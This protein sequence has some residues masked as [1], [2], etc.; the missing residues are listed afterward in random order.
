M[1][2]TITIFIISLLSP[3]KTYIAKACKKLYLAQPTL[4]TQLKQFEKSLGKKLFERD[5]RRLS[6]TEDG[7]LVLDYAE[8]IFELGSEL[9]DTLKDRARPE[10]MAIQVGI[11]NGTPRSFA[12]SLLESILDYDPKAEIHVREA[13]L[14]QLL[15][16]LKEHRL[17]VVMTDTIVR[18]QRRDELINYQVGKIPVV[19]AAAPQIAKKILSFPDDL[20]GTD[21]SAFPA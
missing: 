4:S 20:R 5:K 6:L 10:H 11:L 2:L 14:D 17:D 9:K 21:D 18:G 16:A 8:S 3:R 7:R 12:H 15:I 13:G 19:F 1:N